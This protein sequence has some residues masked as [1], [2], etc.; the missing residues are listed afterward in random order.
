MKVLFVTNA[1]GA[2]YLCDVAFHGLRSLLGPDCVDS[3]RM[4]FMYQNGKD[5]FFHSLYK[6]LPDIEV[7]RDD[8]PN[9][10]RARFYDAVIFGSVAR[11]LDYFNLVRALYP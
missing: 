3:T 9:K 4:D 10:I 8:I 1:H 11:C 6:L 2:D 7:D 5:Y